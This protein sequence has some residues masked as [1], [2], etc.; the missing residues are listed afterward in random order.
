K[1]WGVPAPGV[2]LLEHAAAESERLVDARDGGVLREGQAL[3]AQLVSRVKPVGRLTTQLTE[4][5]G[6]TERIVPLSLLV[7]LLELA[8]G[9]SV[10]EHLGGVAQVLPGVGHPTFAGRQGPERAIGLD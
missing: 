8:V 7:A 6:Q 2:G 9:L 10:G 5:R 3:G 4:S 1:G